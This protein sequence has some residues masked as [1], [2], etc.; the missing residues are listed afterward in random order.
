[1]MELSGL[2]HRRLI[3]LPGFGED[4]RIF[5][6]LRQELRIS[7]PEIIVNYH[8]ILQNFSISQI[9]MKDFL[10]LLINFY[11]INSQDILIGHSFGGWV[12]HHIRQQLYSEAILICSFTSPSHLALRSR[13]LLKNKLIVLAGVLQSPWVYWVAFHRN[14][15][16]PSVIPINH[17]FE[18]L[19]KTSS[20]DLYKIVKLVEAKLPVPV[21]PPSLI[22]HSR[23]DLIISPPSEPHI[24]IPGDHFALHEHAALV[25]RQIRLWYK[26]L[27][28][29]S[30]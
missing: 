6:E 17:I 7:L 20:E 2:N 3:Y 23:Q 8:P 27:S 25:A 11:Q 24:S 13:W 21:I 26:S 5:D 1:M 4:D 30:A 28:I 14:K 18:N 15:K 9:N 22:I 29:K 12:A 10:D 16:R 19:S